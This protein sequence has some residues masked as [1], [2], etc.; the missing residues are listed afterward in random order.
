MA[1]V[2]I[3]S[4]NPRTDH[5]EVQAV[6]TLGPNGVVQVTGNPLVVDRLTHEGIRLPDGRRFTVQDG[7]V[8]LQH[9]KFVFNGMYSSATDVIL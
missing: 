1:H 7:M 5:M 9:L 8:F 6:A 4:I 2:E 3:K